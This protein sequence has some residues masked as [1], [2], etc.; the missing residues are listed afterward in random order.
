MVQVPTAQPHLAPS[1]TLVLSRSIITPFRHDSTPIMSTNIPAL[2]ARLDA[3][4]EKAGSLRTQLV[5]DKERLSDT[6]STP[7]TPSHRL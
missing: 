2:Q 1:T 7:M 5:E 3:V 4:R 6:T